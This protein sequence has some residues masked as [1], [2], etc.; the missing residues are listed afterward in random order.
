MPQ[1]SPPA[2]S[3]PAASAD[4]PPAAQ[5]GWPGGLP[6][7]R[8]EL[9]RIDDEIHTLLRERARVVEHV[10][11]SGKPAAFRPGREASIVRRLLRQH[12]GRLPRL[13]LFRIW[14]EMLAGT[15]GMQA[16]FLVAV[17]A[18]STGDSLSQLAREHFGALTPLRV[19]G[20]AGQALNEVRTGS[21]S[22]AVLPLPTDGDAPRDAWWT[23][24]QQRDQRLHIIARLP[25]W[26]VRPEGAP[27][28]QALVVAASAPDASGEDRAFLAFELDAATSRARIASELAAAGFAPVSIVSCRTPGAPDAQVLVEVEGAVPEG[29]TRLASLSPLFR[30]TLLLGGYAIP[31]GAEP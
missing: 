31:V 23:S 30:H 10:A 24:L 27:T 7:L 25:F 17:A 4:A 18:G 11:R 19:L 3:S 22:V 15:T 13:T 1:I 9:D 5:D 28:E 8:A 26:T 12:E 16:N 6:A 14:R 21:A 20:S 29:D 2:E